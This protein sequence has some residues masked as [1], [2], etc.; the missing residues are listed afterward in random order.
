[1]TLIELLIVTG[2]LGLLI[3]VASSAIFHFTDTIPQGNA[4][5]A[6]LHN[7]QTAARWLSQDGQMAQTVKPTAGILPDEELTLSW[8][9]AY[10]DAWTDHTSKYSLS[11]GVLKR[12][13]DGKEIT[14]AR[15]ISKIEFSLKGEILTVTITSSGGNPKIKEM[16]TYDICLRPT[17][18]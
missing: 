6:A 11:D 8:S 15:Y 7:I 5:L 4:H 3:G 18:T 17:S 9:D 2:L 14:I 1:M 16:K 10:G 12:N 13:Y